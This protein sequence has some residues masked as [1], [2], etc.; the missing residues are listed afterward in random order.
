LT[1]RSKIHRGLQRRGTTGIDSS[2]LVEKTDAMQITVRAG[3]FVDV[4]GNIYTLDSDKVFDISSPPE[5]KY[6][7]IWLANPSSPT[8]DCQ[9]ILQSDLNQ[10]KPWSGTLS[11]SRIQPLIREGWLVVPANATELP[12]PIHAYTWIDNLPLRRKPDGSLKLVGKG[13]KSGEEYEFDEIEHVA[14]LKGKSNIL[15]HC[16]NCSRVDDDQDAITS[17]K[18]LQCGYCGNEDTV[19]IKECD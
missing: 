10:G 13:E 4:Q 9:Y 7:R 12:I 18:G 17:V 6:I 15:R 3:T 11:G 1:V 8:V 5:T 14:R 16:L 2:I 19:R